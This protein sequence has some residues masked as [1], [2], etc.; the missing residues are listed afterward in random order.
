M[1]GH[2]WKNTTTMEKT[3]EKHRKIAHK[4]GKLIFNIFF[5]GS[6]S[7]LFLFHI[8]ILHLISLLLV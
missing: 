8:S 2:L 1:L 3:Y 5:L 4:I 6:L 7:E